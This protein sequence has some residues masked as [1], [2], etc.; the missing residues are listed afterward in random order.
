M[1]NLGFIITFFDPRF[2]T[3]SSYFEICI[4]MQHFRTVALASPHPCCPLLF[5]APH[6]HSLSLTLAAKGQHANAAGNSPS[7]PRNPTQLC[8]IF[9]TETLKKPCILI[10]PRCQL[11]HSGSRSRRKVICAPIL[12]S[13][14]LSHQFLIFAQRYLAFGREI[15]LKLQDSDVNSF[16]CPFS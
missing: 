8:C 3:R 11:I 10:T 2:K 12:T 14:D 6:V 9:D 13:N 5:F 16:V 4:S 7:P 1:I 15:I